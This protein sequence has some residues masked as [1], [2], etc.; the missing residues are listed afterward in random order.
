VD[1]AV[2]LV[3]ATI[4][5]IFYREPLHAAWRQADAAARPAP[6]APAA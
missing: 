1:E 6:P 5:W 3:V 4:V 2:L